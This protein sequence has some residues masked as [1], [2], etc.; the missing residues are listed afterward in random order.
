[1]AKRFAFRL[2]TLMKLRQ[3]QEQIACQAFYRARGEVEL[4]SLHIDQLKRT[5][6]EHNK[7][8]REVVLKGGGAAALSVY[9]QLY[10]DIQNA[11]GQEI[12]SLNLAE[13]ALQRRREEL[14]KAIRQ[15]KAI[16]RFRQKTAAR[17]DAGLRRADVKESDD[18]YASHTAVCGEEQLET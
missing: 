3:Q 5:L 14:T 11:I 18:L 2:E 10:D 4:L 7:L 15:R 12:A 6:D 8:A 17:H 13:L 1:M 9:C 16:D